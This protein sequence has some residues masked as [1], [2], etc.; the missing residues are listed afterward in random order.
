M[1]FKTHNA[2]RQAIKEY[3]VGTRIK[4]IGHRKKIS[5][6]K[7]MY[8][9]VTHADNHCIYVKLDNGRTVG[10]PIDS[11]SFEKVELLFHYFLPL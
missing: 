7:V 2:M 10:I 9:T 8:G 4:S 11:K 3:P 6:P 1:K 5:E